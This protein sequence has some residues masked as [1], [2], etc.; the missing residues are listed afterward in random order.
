M[1]GKLNRSERLI[2]LSGDPAVRY[3]LI[4]FIVSRFFLTLWAVFVLTIQPLPEEPNELFRPYLGEPRLV[5]GP[6]GLLL[7]PWQRFDTNHYLRIAR[8]GYGVEQESVFPPL[9]PL[10]IRAGGQLFRGFMP[11]GQANLVAAIL[12]SNLAFIGVLVLLHRLTTA[13]MDEASA[14]RSLVYL[15]I[16]PTG[17]FLI[18]GY[19]ES[20]FIFF[21]LASIMASRRGDFWL[22]GLLG[23][24][25]SL[26]RLTGWILVAPMAYEYMRQ[27]DF[28]FR[29]LQADVLGIALPLLGSGAFLAYRSMIGLPSIGQIYQEYWY[30]IVGFPGQDLVLALQRILAGGAAVTLFFD[31]FCAIFLL[32]STIIVFRRLGPTFGLYSAMLL[33]FIFLP[34]SHFKP[35]FSFSRYV[36][37]FFPTFMLLGEAGRNPWI[38]RLIVYPSIGLYLYFSGQFFIW[39]WVA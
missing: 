15:A 1:I 31:L 38:N 17:F 9:Y 36:L 30:Q 24:L 19:T 7:G 2:S 8:E 26:T 22:A 39:G 18:A 23:L 32:I 12:I 16:F 4:V 37:A 34:T 13:E 3:A 14:K 33:L 5:D 25:A 20:L 35:L 28:K 6:G 21:A 10:A 27:R 11:L 29:R